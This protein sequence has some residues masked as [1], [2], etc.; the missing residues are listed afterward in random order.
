MKDIVLLAA[1]AN[2]SSDGGAAFVGFII[3]CFLIGAIISALNKKKTYDVR[4]TVRER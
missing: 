3:I 1:D 2:A 4:G